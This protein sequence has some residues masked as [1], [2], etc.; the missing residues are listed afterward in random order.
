MPLPRDIF[1]LIFR[2]PVLIVQVMVDAPEDD[3]MRD[4][5]LMSRN[6]ELALAPLGV[7]SEFD[8]R[9]AIRVAVYEWLSAQHPVLERCRCLDHKDGLV[10]EVAPGFD[11]THPAPTNDQLADVYSLLSDGWCRRCMEDVPDLSDLIPQDD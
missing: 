5:T 9:R 8:R 1:V 10:S 3:G 7:I 11:L 4:A 2:H 6:G